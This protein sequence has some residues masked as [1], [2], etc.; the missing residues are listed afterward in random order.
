MS[1]ERARETVGCLYIG[2]LVPGPRGSG[3]C[4]R[5]ADL[6]GVNLHTFR[7][8]CARTLW[9][10]L[11]MSLQRLRAEWGECAVMAE[12]S[13]CAA[14]LALASQLPVERV[15]RIDPAPPARLNSLRGQ[16]LNREGNPETA[17]TRRTLRRLYGFARKN[18]SLCVCD[19][20]VVECGPGDG[21][22]ALRRAF[23]NPVNCSV[24]Q[25]SLRGGCAK[26]L[27][28]IREFAVKEAISRY[29][30]GKEAP[31]PLAENSDLCIIYG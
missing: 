16:P 25:L 15:V 6:P 14:A 3:A 8:S 19:M 23:G 29:L 18:L 10:E 27:Y 28:T 20:L 1:N 13:G 22:R 9:D 5:V 12:G 21:V 24:R 31:K 26:E 17:R 11:Q 4:H 7:F 30:H 2:E